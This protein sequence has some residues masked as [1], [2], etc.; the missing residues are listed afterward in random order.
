MITLNA[1]CAIHSKAFP[2]LG[3]WLIEFV[4]VFIITIMIVATA[5]ATKNLG[6]GRDEKLIINF[7]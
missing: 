1:K 6:A 3:F 5:A 4:F 2:V 7:I